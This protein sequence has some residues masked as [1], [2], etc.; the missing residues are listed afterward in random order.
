MTL[1][2]GLMKVAQEEREPTSRGKRSPG[3]LHGIRPHPKHTSS[4]KPFRV[5]SNT[6]AGLGTWSSARLCSVHADPAV[7]SRFKCHI[8]ENER[9]K[10]FNQFWQLPNSHEKMVFRWP[11]RETDRRE[12]KQR[13]GEQKIA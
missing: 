4:K 1:E 7:G 8:E 12:G 11:T 3:R 10:I 9:Q 2:S 5:E 6:S 13:A